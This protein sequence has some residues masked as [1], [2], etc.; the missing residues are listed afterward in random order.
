[1]ITEYKPPVFPEVSY[2]TSIFLGGSIEMGEARDWQKE[3]VEKFTKIKEEGYWDGRE[4]SICNP[5]RDDWDN[6]W[7]QTIKDPNFFQQVSWELTYLDRCKHKVFYFAENTVSPIT[8]F[9]LGIFNTHREVYIC[10]HPDY[11]RRGNLE[12]YCHMY[13]ETLFSSL[14]EVIK[15]ILKNEPNTIN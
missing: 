5:R 11:L 6:T 4:W 3:F 14:D 10:A 13:H 8:L 7:K 12:V 1:M 9:E 15:E 2:D